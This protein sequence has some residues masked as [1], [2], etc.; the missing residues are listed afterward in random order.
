M[1]RFLQKRND[2]RVNDQLQAQNDLADCIIETNGL[3]QPRPEY[4]YKPIKEDGYIRLFLLRTEHGAVD[5]QVRGQ[6]VV[7]PLKAIEDD[8]VAISY[9]W[10]KEVLSKKIIIEQD[11][12]EFEI[13]ITENLYAT[14]TEVAV[15]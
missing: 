7:K 9:V 3:S 4:S 5:R 11:N 1:K 15:V 6:L 12:D 13:M 8:Y 14:L 2:R 10:G